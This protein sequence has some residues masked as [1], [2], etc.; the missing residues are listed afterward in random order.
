MA[1]VYKRG[2]RYWI[3]YWAD[4]KEHRE[5]A[6]P[7]KRDAERALGA[8]LKEIKE[9]RF[10]DIKKRCKVTLEEFKPRYMEWAKASK[11][12]WRRDKV[13]L[14]NLCTR[15]GNMNLKEITVSE[16][17]KYKRA[18]LAGTLVFGYKVPTEKDGIKTVKTIPGKVPSAATVN[19]E[20][21]CLTKVLNLAVDLGV[22]AENPLAGKVKMLREPTGRMRYLKP[23]E[24][25]K[26]LSECA[27]HLR[28][29]VYLA[30]LTG[31]RKGEILGLR[32]DE[33]DLGRGVIR[34]PGERTKN[35]RSKVVPLAREAAQVIRA[36]HKARS[37]GCLYV[38][39]GSDGGKRGDVR[40]SFDGACRRAGIQ[41]FTFHD[42]RHCFASALAMR[43]VPLQAIGELLGHQSPTMTKRYA[44]LS[45]Q[46]LQGAVEQASRYIQGQAPEGVVE[47]HKE[48][49]NGVNA[50]HTGHNTSTEKTEGVVIALNSGRS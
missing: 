26:L 41:D 3:R 50:P 5:S 39:P 37:K 45:P 23:E 24:I 49:E 40:K 30:M 33:V 9:G 43:G 6:G 46:A 22:L 18:R 31:M 42:L 15:F 7:S 34:L 29:I 44:H 48:A 16:V 13:S 2:K 10:Y 27:D 11:R 17:E 20:L 28:P 35:G 8:R 12:S 36:A 21:R 14:R 38:F 25:G 19:R 47:L 4:G 1:S 32:W